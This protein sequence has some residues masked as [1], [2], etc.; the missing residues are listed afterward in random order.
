MSYGYFF[1][2][3]FMSNPCLSYSLL[4]TILVCMFKGNT[5]NYNP[6]GFVVSM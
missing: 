4:E 3:D 2:E 1:V 6:F 5:S